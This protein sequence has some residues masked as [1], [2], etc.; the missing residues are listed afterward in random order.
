MTQSGTLNLL[1]IEINNLITNLTPNLPPGDTA[2]LHD[3]PWGSG[4]PAAG[5]CGGQGK[6][7]AGGG[8]ESAHSAVCCQQEVSLIYLNFLNE[9]NYAPYVSHLRQMQYSRIPFFLIVSP[10]IYGHKIMST[11]RR[12]TLS[13]LSFNLICCLSALLYFCLNPLSILI[14][15]L[16]RK[17]HPSLGVFCFH[18]H[19]CLSVCARATEHIIWPMT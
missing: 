7:R 19:V 6:T 16:F 12:I 15:T 11:S 9:L 13:F 8:E 18:F 17:K 4:G 1:Q 14:V 2:K 3:H 5:Y 10:E